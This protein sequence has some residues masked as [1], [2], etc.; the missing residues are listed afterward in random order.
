MQFSTGSETVDEATGS[1]SIAV[2]LAGTST[3][4]VTVPFTLGGTAAAG[5]D[6]SG[7]T[8]APLT[9]AAGQTTAN[10]TGNLVADPGSSRTLTLTLGTP[11][12]GA[13]LGSSAV[14]TLTITEPVPATV[15]F[16]TASETVNETT[17]SFSIA[18]TRSGTSTQA[19][20]VPFTL[21]GTAVA[22]TDYS[23]VTAAPLTFA[24]GQT[25]ANI[26]GNLVADPGSSRTLTLTLGTPTGARTLGSSAVNTL[27]ITEPVPTVQFSTASETVNKTTGSFDIAVTLAGTSTQAVTVPFTLGGT[28]VAGTDYSGVTAAPLTFAAGQTTAN[29]TGNLVADPGSSRTLT[30][31]LGTPTGGATLGSS[32]VNTLTITEP[33]PTVQ[34]ST[35]SETVNETTGSFSIAVTLAGTSTQAVTVPFTLGGTAVAGTDYSGVTA[36]PLT[37]AAG[38]TTANITGNL[39]ADP[40]SSRTLTLTLGTPT[41]G[42]TLGSSAVNTLTITEPVPTVQFSTASET[43]NETTGSFSIAVTLAG[44]STQAVTVPFTLGGTA[45]AGTDYSGVTAAPL[46]FAAGRP[47]RTS[48]ATSSPTP[49]PAE[50]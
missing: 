15:Q 37:F 36:A 47:R 27:T 14:N 35:A 5:T 7:V 1:F 41:G 10:I 21:G 9:F 13:T 46:T 3:Q 48:P 4:A 34:F 32:A 39:V 28:A 12:G 8:A 16:R 24:A 33:V 43:V 49:A 26:T 44:T 31:T 50:R 23:G 2:T 19:V 40:G 45:V 11:T 29:I 20:T 38:Q 18:V 30:L 22:G 42:A 6:Y 25:T 17:G